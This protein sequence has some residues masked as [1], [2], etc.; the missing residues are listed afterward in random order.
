MSSL[1]QVDTQRK[2]GKRG[3][4]EEGEMCCAERNVPIGTLSHCIFIYTVS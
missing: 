4:K 3:E 2:V 1:L